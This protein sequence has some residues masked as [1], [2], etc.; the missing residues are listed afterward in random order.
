MGG[1]LGVE[2]VEHRGSSFWVDLPRAS[3]PEDVP[4]SADRRRT[5]VLKGSGERKHTVLLIEDN[6]ANVRLMERLLQRRPQVKL[7]TAM[8]GRL[9]LDLAR[10]HCPDLI[11]L[12][13]NLPDITG[14]KVLLRLREDAALSG[15]P[16]IMI[17]GDAI[18]S[19][20]ER[21]LGLGARAYVTKPFDI[22]EFLRVLDENLG[23]AADEA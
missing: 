6:V 21:M 1:R 11:L 7:I 23:T 14:D 22:H 16:V 9:G 2:S 3:T 10:E 13:V 17:S 8:Q 4:P 18:P 20:V 19:Q 15:I 5:G 12:D